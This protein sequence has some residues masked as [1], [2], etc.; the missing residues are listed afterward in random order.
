MPF[1][2]RLR[3]RGITE[4]AIGSVAHALVWTGGAKWLSQLASWFS[5]IVVARLLT[6]DDFGLVGMAQILLG[7]AAIL[8]EFGLGTAIIVHPHL[9]DEHVDQLNA[10]AV[11]VGTGTVILTC[12]AARPLGQFFMAPNLPMVVMAASS[13]FASTALRTVPSA[14][15]QKELKFRYLAIVESVQ[16]AVAAAAMLGL[17]VLGFHYWALVISPVLGSFVA[18]GLTVLGRP[19]SFARPR[20]CTLSSILTESRRL[21]L[22]RSAWWFQNNVD[23]II[24]ARVLGEGALGVY[25]LA[26]A[27]ASLPLEKI[28]ALVNQ[29]SAPFLA[30]TRSDRR[31]MRHLLLILS[32]VL[33]VVVFPVAAG[34]AIVAESFVLAALGAKWTAVVFP[35][36]ILSVLA[37]L[38]CIVAALAPVVVVTGGTRLSMY[39][40]LVEALLMS[41]VL[42]VASGFGVPGVALAWLLTYPFLRMPFYWWAFREL[43]LTPAQYL[44]ALWPALR[45]TAVMAV[46][47]IVIEPIY[48]PGL[49][50]LMHLILQVAIG[51]VTY[52]IASLA[53]R[54]RLLDMYR[55]FRTLGRAPTSTHG[56]LDV[57]GL[58]L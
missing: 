36:R 20:L 26:S 33:S 12:A 58:P 45:A 24:I 38:R 49:S 8:T 7:L 19:C 46:A 21:L 32:G 50:A 39:V 57:L 40:S 3:Q 28:T 27:V 44:N 1:L 23:S 51:A 35:L 15:L 42:Y 41:A 22:G 30:A 53:Q 5:M 2:S 10:V 9:T 55:E 48:P 54:R 29:V 47:V 4:A 52:A 34:L 6:P 25:T 56:Q 37:A 17:A 43:G 16:A 31:A 18:T 14:L 13:M 11:L